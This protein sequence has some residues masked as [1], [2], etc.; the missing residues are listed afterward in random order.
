[1]HPEQERERQRE[2]KRRARE[3]D[4]ERLREIT[5]RWRAA[6]PEQYRASVRAAG[7]RLRERDRAAVFER[8]GR[9]CACCGT[10]NSPTID[11]IDGTGRQHREQVGRALYRWLV[12]NGF[13]EGFQT[14]CR[15]CNRSKGSGPACG[16]RHDAA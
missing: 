6:N 5:R 9:T 10:T 2:V 15:P 1:M 3:T 16:L 4:P 14:L 7:Q 13:P 11:H 8:Y 12:K